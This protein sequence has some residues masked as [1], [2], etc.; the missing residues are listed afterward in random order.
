MKAERIEAAWHVPDNV[1]KETRGWFQGGLAG[2]H[3]IW[4]QLEPLP[5]LRGVKTDIGGTGKGQERSV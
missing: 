1:H 4:W 5:R 3:F 2:W